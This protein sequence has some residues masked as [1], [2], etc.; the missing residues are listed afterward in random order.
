[1]ENRFLGPTGIKVSVI[2]FGNWLNSDSEKAK[3][4]T[5]DCVKKAWDLGV[6]FFDT[7][8]LYGMIPL[9]IGFDRL[10]DKLERL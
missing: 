2:S 1:M 8:E 6:N 3:Q 10:K 4:N 7:A 9:I 5:I